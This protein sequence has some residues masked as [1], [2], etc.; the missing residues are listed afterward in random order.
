MAGTLM[1]GLFG[2]RRMG[3]T[4]GINPQLGADIARENGIMAGDRPG[5]PQAPAQQPTQPKKRSTGRRIAGYFADFAAGLAGQQ[6]PYAAML[7]REQ[8]QRDQEAQYQRQRAD[9]FADWE[10]RQRWE[11]AN[12]PSDASLQYFD[13]NAGNRYSYNPATGERRLIF[14]DPNDK[15][16]VQDG[17]LVTVPNVVRTGPSEQRQTIAGKTYV[18]R[19]NDWFEEGGPASAPG[20]FPLGQ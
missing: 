7:Q 13:D 17:Q 8:A 18:K 4:P 15:V 5:L 9:Q 11:M 12:K 16:F 10:R 3:W 14:T 19:G 2:S 6:G 20:N 1:G